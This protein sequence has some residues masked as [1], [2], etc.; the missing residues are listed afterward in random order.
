F[1]YAFTLIVGIKQRYSVLFTRALSCKATA[2]MEGGSDA[3]AKN[4]GRGRADR[5]C[6]LC[7][8]AAQRLRSGPGSG[9]VGGVARANPPRFLRRVVAASVVDRRVAARAALQRR[10]TQSAGAMGGEPRRRSFVPLRHSARPHQ[11]R[12]STRL[13]SSHVKI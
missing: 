11:D 2:P 4:R 13:N 8:R 3:Y 12:K 7:R 1:A 10:G 9:R 5:R 6:R